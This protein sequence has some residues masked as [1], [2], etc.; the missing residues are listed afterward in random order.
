MRKKGFTLIELLVVISIIALLLSILLPS[1][2]AAKKKA[3]GVICT[4]NINGLSKG[5]YS[6]SLDN[7]DELVSGNVPRYPTQGMDISESRK[8]FWVDAPQNE[9]KQYTGEPSGPPSLQE[10]QLGIRRGALYYYIGNLKSYRCPGDRSRRLVPNND[11]PFAE[12]YSFRSYSV[13][14]LLNGWKLNDPQAVTKY[15][16]IVSPGNK[17]VFMGTTDTRGWNMGS[18][19]FQYRDDPPKSDTV[20]VWHGDR[21]G[22]GY[23]DGHGE[24]HKWKDEYIINAAQNPQVDW[25]EYKDPDSEDLQFLLKGYIPGLRKRDRE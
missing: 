1:L 16:E 22:F 24:L 15:G 17:F 21:S 10:K 3:Q 13:S 11:N 18:W 2:K 8:D 4:S 19:N 14:E 6:Y 25:F 12:N 5:H 23:A 7:H 20:A 9:Q